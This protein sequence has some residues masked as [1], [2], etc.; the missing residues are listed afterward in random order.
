MRGNQIARQWR[1]L[2]YIESSRIGLTAEEIAHRVGALLRT[3]YRD[4]SDLQTGGF[5][6]YTEKEGRHQ[7]WKLVENDSLNI[8]YPLCWTEFRCSA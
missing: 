3:V 6:L 5:P 8:P 7:R 1:I 4:L 2:R